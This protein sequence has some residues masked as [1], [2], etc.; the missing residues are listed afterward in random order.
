MICRK[1][2]VGRPHCPANLVPIFT[3]MGSAKGR[4]MADQRNIPQLKDLF[5]PEA[6]IPDIFS[7]PVGDGDNGHVPVIHRTF[8]I[9][10]QI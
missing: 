4:Q 1:Q 10:S 8:A 7:A 2:M 6:F 3:A 9:A 5:L